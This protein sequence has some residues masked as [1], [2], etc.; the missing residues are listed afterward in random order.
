MNFLSNNYERAAAGEN[1]LKFAPNDQAKIR[2]ISDSIEGIQVFVK[3]DGKNKPI[4][5]SYEGEMPKEA[6]GADDSPR[7][8]AAFGV[9]NYDK[10]RYQIWQCTTRSVLQE[11]ANLSD[12]E[13][14][15]R[16][17]DITITRKGAGLDTKYYVKPQKPAQMEEEVQLAAQ[18]FALNVDLSA[19]LTGENP[20]K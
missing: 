11:L 5:W 17:Y 20:F 13:G 3:V 4:R 10:N 7:P 12:V 2:I 9:W 15:P 19:L 1:Y 18:A 14:D 6:Y 8:F 16:D